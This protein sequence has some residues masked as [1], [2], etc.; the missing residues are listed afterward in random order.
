M[1]EVSKWAQ[2]EN[3]FLAALYWLTSGGADSGGS[4]N[5]LL[6]LALW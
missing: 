4:V 6:Y 1:V 5:L 3:M 2:C